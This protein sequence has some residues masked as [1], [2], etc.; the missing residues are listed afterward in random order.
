MY[1]LPPLTRTRGRLTGRVARCCRS[2]P[3]KAARIRTGYLPLLAGVATRSQQERLAVCQIPHAPTRSAINQRSRCMSPKSSLRAAARTNRY[4]LR[5]A[6]GRQRNAP[7]QQVHCDSCRG[8]VLERGGEAARVQDLQNSIRKDREGDTIGK[9]FGAFVHRAGEGTL[10]RLLV[11]GRS[12][13]Q[14]HAPM[15]PLS[16]AMLPRSTKLIRTLLPK[17]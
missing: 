5:P 15:P 16:C 3:Y 10:S 17:R 13:W 8:A 12:S 4:G 2:L 7:V 1:F 9:L 14:R 11:E 6:E